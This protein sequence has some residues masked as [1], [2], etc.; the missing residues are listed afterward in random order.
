MARRMFTDLS[1]SAVLLAIYMCV[2]ACIVS[3]EQMVRITFED[4]DDHLPPSGTAEV[5]EHLKYKDWEHSVFS[6]Y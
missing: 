1:F 6:D 5:L 3:A 2:T 4:D